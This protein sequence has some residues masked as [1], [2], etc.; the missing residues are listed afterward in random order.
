MANPV[1]I[2]I[3][4]APND[5]SYFEALRNHLAVLERNTN[6][7]IWYEFLVSLRW[8]LFTSWLRSH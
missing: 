7:H 5:N 8:V 3:A 2:F 1:N 4:Y 6:V